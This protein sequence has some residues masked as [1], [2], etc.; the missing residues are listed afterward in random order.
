MLVITA[1]FIEPLFFVEPTARIFVGK[2]K[3]QTYFQ[4]FCFH[5]FNGTYRTQ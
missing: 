3:N 5:E 2:K 4:S 1:T